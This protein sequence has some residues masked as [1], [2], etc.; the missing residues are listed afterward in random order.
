MI[1]A[2]NSRMES[3]RQLKFIVMLSNLRFQRLLMIPGVGRHFYL[4]RRCDRDLG[5]RWLHAFSHQPRLIRSTQLLLIR[6][7]SRGL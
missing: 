2:D 7:V 6:L 5:C 3:Q 4:H 1:A